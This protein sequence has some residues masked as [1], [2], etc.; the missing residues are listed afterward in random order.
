MAA[1][2]CDL[3]RVLPDQAHVL[4]SKLFGSEVFHPRQ[5][6]GRTRLAP[7]LGARTGPAELLARVDAAV[8]VLPDHVHHLAFAIDV[9]VDRKR[10]GVLQLGAGL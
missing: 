3:E 2:K 8:P 4:K 5:S 9:D 6:P 1:L 10:I 7:T